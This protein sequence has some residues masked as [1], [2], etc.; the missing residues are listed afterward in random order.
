MLGTD[1][2]REE[3]FVS[4][5][6]AV[7]MPVD[8]HEL[9]KNEKD[10]TY[11]AALKACD[12]GWPTSAKTNVGEYWSAR[13]DLT[14]ENE[15][16]FYNGRLVIPREARKNVLEFLHRGHVG[17]TTML[18]RAEDSVWWPG[19]R[20][21][22]R[23]RVQKCGDCYRIM[24]SQRREPMM[25]FNV[26]ET[27]GQV[28]HADYFDWAAKDYLIV[29]DGMS[30]WTEVFAM[31]GMRPSEL[32]RVMRV[33]M[34][35]NGTP[36]IFHTDQGSTFESKEFQD[37]CERWGIRFSD[38][39]AKHPRG[40]AIAEAHVKKVKHLLMTAADDDDL[41]RSM[42]AM[43]QTPIAPG[44]PSPSEL[45]LGRRVRDE[46]HPNARRYQGSWEEFRGWKQAKAEHQAKYFNRGTRPLPQLE[47][48]DEVMI[49]H[50]EEWQRGVVEAKLPRPRSYRVRIHQTGQQLE[51]NRVQ[52]RKIPSDTSE[53]GQK[54]IKPFHLFQQALQVPSNPPLRTRERRD[55]P[56]SPDEEEDDPAS[57]PDHESNQFESAES[58]YELDHPD[59]DDDGTESEETSEEDDEA[60]PATTTR[61]GRRCRPPDRYTPS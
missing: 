6:D 4:M 28:V 29:V 3:A 31:N 44:Q 46:I 50:R 51:R 26:P 22:A 40:N 16:L 35:R 52:L 47:P 19:L 20:N 25:S 23:K 38:N 59:D 1:V 21:E 39:S 43:M 8:V 42:I 12:D 2:E 27:P 17:F 7:E 15:L 32:K 33:Y 24:P 54:R 37:F 11:I 13:N 56:D 14:N 9:V 60:P 41:A 34:M 58:E 5:I 18:K 36:Q 53:E 57:D 30:G 55:E 61:A 48:G 49:W 10:E 45:H